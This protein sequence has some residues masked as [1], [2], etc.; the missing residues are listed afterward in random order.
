MG[1]QT[2]R[3]TEIEHNGVASPEEH[4]EE[5]EKIFLHET[6]AFEEE[7]V[8]LEVKLEA[9]MTFAEWMNTYVK[10]NEKK[11]QALVFFAVKLAEKIEPHII[12]ASHGGVLHV[13]VWNHVLFFIL[14][15]YIQQYTGRYQGGLRFKIQFK[16]TEEHQY[17][18]EIGVTEPGVNTT[19]KCFRKDGVVEP[20]KKPEWFHRIWRTAI[21]DENFLGYRLPGYM[22]KINQLANIGLI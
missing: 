22:F 15:S 16:V 3:Q 4:I 5:A 12:A 2:S 9:G 7:M 6:R 21:H 18:S 14:V 19:I 11:A 8:D 20:S 1:G 10:E 13:A 17:A